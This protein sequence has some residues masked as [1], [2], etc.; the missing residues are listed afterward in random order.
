MFQEVKGEYNTAKIY[1]DIVDGNALA[2]IKSLCDQE[3]AKGLSFPWN[4]SSPAEKCGQKP[5][6]RMV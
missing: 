3:Y 4:C 5:D 1:T 6:I 2:Q